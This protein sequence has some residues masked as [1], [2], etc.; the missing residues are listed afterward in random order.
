MAREVES[1]AV[2]TTPAQRARYERVL[3]AGT[4][5]LTAGGEDALQMKELA[6]RAEVSLDTLYR[7]FPSKEHV[8]AAIAV[9]RYERAYQKVVADPPHGGS[10]RERVT[11]YLLREFGTGQRNEKLTAALVRVRHQTSRAYGEVVEGLFQ[12]HLDIL[13]VVGESRGPMTEQQRRSL[14]VVAQVF[15]FAMTGWLSGMFSAADSRFQIRLGCRLLDLPDEDVTQD[16]EEARHA[17]RPA[18]L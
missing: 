5:I 2:P 10:V 17:A 13:R 1:P 6:Q 18:H 4:D 14:T 9:D 11:D 16:L 12:R 7:Y 3:R 15:G 8:L